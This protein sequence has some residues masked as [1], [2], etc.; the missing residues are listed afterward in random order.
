[1]ET[2]GLRPA[3]RGEALGAEVAG[4]LAAWRRAHPRATLAEIEGVVL[5][6]VGRLQAR[7]LGDLAQASAAAEGGPAAGGERPRCLECGGALE[8]R[9]WHAREVLIP[10]QRAPLRLRRRYLACPACGA[11]LFPPGRGIGAAARGA[12]PDA[13]GGADAAS[14]ADAV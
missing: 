12:E 11:G 7:F 14:G 10:R 4:E 3:L 2:E 6:G 13:G 1:M 9:G 8:G 5:E